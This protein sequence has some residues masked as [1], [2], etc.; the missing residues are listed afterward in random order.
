M[1]GKTMAKLSAHGQEIGR[2]FYTTYAK[3]YMADRK[4]LKNTGSGWKIGGT[5]K[6]GLTPEGA[7]QNAVE[8]Q[9]GS[10]E[11]AVSDILQWFLYAPLSEVTSWIVGAFALICVFILGE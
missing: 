1:K 7:Y 10:G 4:I 6:D 5:L 3:A 9:R 11:D 2:I 8:L